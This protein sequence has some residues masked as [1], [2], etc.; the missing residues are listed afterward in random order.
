[1][2]NR[3]R[4]DLAWQFPEAAQILCKRNG[5]GPPYSGVGWR[6]FGTRTSTTSLIPVRLG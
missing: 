1:M 2:V 3:L 5:V 4:Q 6:E